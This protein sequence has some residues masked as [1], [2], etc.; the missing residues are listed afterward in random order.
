M[1]HYEDP[2]HI[3]YLYDFGYGD[4]SCALYALGNHYGNVSDNEYGDDNYD[5]DLPGWERDPS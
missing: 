1:R 3:D 5:L 2:V 4:S